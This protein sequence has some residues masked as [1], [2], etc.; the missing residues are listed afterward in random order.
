MKTDAAQLKITLN[1]NP[2][3]KIKRQVEL[4]GDYS[5]IANRRT[6]ITA[7]FWGV[8]VEGLFGIFAMFQN[9]Y[10]FIR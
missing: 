7:I 1:M 3:N 9:C 4:H 6:K 2:L 5:S 10:I 8:G